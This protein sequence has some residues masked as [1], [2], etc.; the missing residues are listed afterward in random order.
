MEGVRHRF[1]AT[2]ALDG[3]DLDVAPGEVHA[4]VGENGAGKSTLMKVLSGALRPDAGRLW[5][6][7]HPYAP[8]TPADGRRAGVAMIY[9]E[10]ALA[11]H[12]SVQENLLLGDE[13][14]AGPFLRRG[15]MRRRAAAAMAQVGRPDFPLDRPAGQLPVAEQ[16]LVEIARSLTRGCRV[17]ILDEPTSSLAH[18]DIDRL[19]A[20]IRRLRTA[21]QSI[22]YISHVLEEVHAVSDRLTVL[23]D[24]RAV[25]TSVTDDM[26]D[27][28]IIKL[29]IGRSVG[30]M[31]P[32]SPRTPGE[33]ILEVRDLAGAA[34]PRAASLTVRRGEVLGIAGLLGAG[35]TE[36]IR[37]I[38]GLDP[39]RRG[40]VTVAGLTGAAAPGR[41]WRQ[42]AGMVSEDRKREGLAGNLGVAENL[43]M[44]SFRRFGR[45]GLLSPE[46][47]R[48]A[49]ARW[50][51]EL[52]IVCASPGQPAMRLSGGNQQ[53]VTL[54]R[55]LEA[56]VDL[57]LLDEPTRGI[58]IGAKT[59]VYRLI[60]ELAQPDAETGRPARAILL[61]SSELPELLGLC[62]RIS[63]MQRGRLGPA[64]PAAELDAHRI[65]RLATGAEALA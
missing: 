63:V 26:S 43:T 1:G 41:R 52:Q 3:V 62:D 14:T 35:R 33:V 54:A 24:G 57:L 5:L 29:M 25:G 7:G 23:R 38:F 39:V 44:P 51:D 61:I 16:Q 9:Q 21:G 13:P 45:W 37:A 31:Y 56:D 55:L 32:R 20:L 48:R 4:L 47:Q 17:L 50:I 19:F 60:D 27:D 28:D 40:E 8:R 11:P 59:L 22:I 10:L 30:E 18:D 12:L 2:I 34:R 49:A 65:M 64:M 36:L 15:E 42:G 46:R 58:D 53:K 6:D